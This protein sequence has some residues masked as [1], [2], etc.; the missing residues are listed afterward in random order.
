MCVARPTRLRPVALGRLA[1][2]SSLTLVPIGLG[3]LGSGQAHARQPLSTADTPRVAIFGDSIA[4]SMLFALFNA[5]TEREFVIVADDVH[6]GCGIALWGRPAAGVSDPC[7]DPAERY[8][9]K[10]VARDVDV[11]IM[12]SCQWELISQRLPGAE[13]SPPSTPG[14]PEFDAF[15]TTSYVHV[16]D[17][18]ADAGVERIL[19]MRCPYLSHA[20][21]MGGLPLTVRA[22]RASERVDWL[23][24]IV[25]DLAADRDDVEVLPFDDWV[26][27]RVDDPTIRPDG[28][29]YEWPEPRGSG[30]V[31]RDRQRH[32]RRRLNVNQTASA[33]S[34]SRACCTSTVS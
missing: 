12:I 30:R 26:N 4:F 27:E 10:S 6:L 23:N 3:P 29:H 8:F 16:A 14:D 11:A 19:W 18:L 5:T 13:D 9:L 21:G 15:V 24:A 32:T 34:R 28:S 7:A 33:V 2:A 17:R 31:H 22:S 20:V 25:T 1:L